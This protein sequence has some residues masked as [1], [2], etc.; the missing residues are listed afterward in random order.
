MVC[1]LSFWRFKKKLEFDRVLQRRLLL[2]CCNYQ[3]L[4]KSN[5]LGEQHNVHSV[6]F[7]TLVSPCFGY[8]M[9]QQSTH[10][11][12]FF[13]GINCVVT[14]RKIDVIRSNFRLFCIHFITS[15]CWRSVAPCIHRWTAVWKF[16]DIK[17]L[18]DFPGSLTSD[19]IPSLWLIQ[20]IS[21]IVKN[22]FKN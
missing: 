22:S 15:L 5:L 7:G 16:V 18:L 14:C 3:L 9:V 6:R 17:P 12:V 21:V 11:A 2:Y 8:K 1:F 20:D 4:I 13:G 19:F 10:S